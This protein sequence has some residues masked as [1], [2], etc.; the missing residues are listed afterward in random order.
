MSKTYMYTQ[1][2]TFYLHVDA[3]TQEAADAI[4]EDI[5]VLADEVRATEYTGWALE[6]V[7]E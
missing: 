4:A 7:T 5:D 3:E 2:V 1:T 6:R